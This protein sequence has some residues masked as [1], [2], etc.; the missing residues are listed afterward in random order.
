MLDRIPEKR[1]E[2]C[3]PL[4]ASGAPPHRQ[5]LSPC[6]NRCLLITPFYIAASVTV[7][8]FVLITVQKTAP[9]CWMGLLLSHCTACILAAAHCFREISF[10][11]S[12]WFGAKPG[13]GADQG[14]SLP[15][16]Y[17]SISTTS[18]LSPVWITNGLIASISQMKQY[19]LPSPLTSTSCN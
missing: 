11:P 17:A 1:S 7:S 15:V 18:Q 12:F 3:F 16:L 2:T 19:F 8:G 4:L 10:T 9:D 5:S 6:S 13:P 14:Q